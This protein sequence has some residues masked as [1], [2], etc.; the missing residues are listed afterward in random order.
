MP[1]SS[2]YESW[3]DAPSPARAFAAYIDRMQGLYQR[4]ARLPQVTF[5]EIG[6]AAMGGGYELALACDLRMAADDAKFGLP[7]TGIGLI[8]SAGG[9]QR[10][11]RLCGRGV[12]SK[13]ILGC[14]SVDGRTAAALGMVQWSVP[15]SELEK[16]AQATAE[17]IAGLSVAALQAAKLCIAAATD[18]RNHGYGMERELGSGLLDNEN[19]QERIARFLERNTRSAR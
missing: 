11:T 13:I 9:T 6:G 2:S 19:T 14:E 15:R 4:L 16:M 3:K 7:E 18:D 17:R 10:L 8:P 12:A 5:S 1:T